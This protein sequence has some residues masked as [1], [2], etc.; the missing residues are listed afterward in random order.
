MKN[1]LCYSMLNWKIR[2]AEFDRI[3]SITPININDN[4]RYYRI[5]VTNVFY[6]DTDEA[7]EAAMLVLAKSE[8]AVTYKGKRYMFHRL[9]KLCM[10][11]ENEHNLS[12]IETL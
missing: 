1:S 12:A 10:V 11:V 4:L 3:E 8:C 7:V 9:D 5:Y 2:Y 6:P